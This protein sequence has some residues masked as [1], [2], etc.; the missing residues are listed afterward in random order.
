MMPGPDFPTGG[1]LMG[2]D[3]ARN[4]YATGQGRLVVRGVATIEEAGSGSRGDRIIV[5]GFPYQVNKAQWITAIAEM[6]RRS[7]STASAI[8]GT[9]RTRKGSGW[10]SAPERDDSPG[11]PEQSLQAYRA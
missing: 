4:V 8:S 9:N 5:T 1:I 6:V 3:G 11:H 2:T 7:G 10:S